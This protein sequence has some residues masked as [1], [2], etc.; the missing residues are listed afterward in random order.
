MSAAE[1]LKALDTAA[2]D[3]PW[4]T[5]PND[6]SGGVKYVWSDTHALDIHLRYEQA[7]AVLVA[8]LRSSLPQIV[9]VV[10]AAETL[11][12]WWPDETHGE[13]SGEQFAPI[14]AALAALDSALGGET[15]GDWRN[16]IDTHG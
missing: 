3:G 2:T 5:H 13:I 14:R 12:A 9:A 7:D 1:K 15:K 10:E 11:Q 4:H 6:E 8:A 16:L